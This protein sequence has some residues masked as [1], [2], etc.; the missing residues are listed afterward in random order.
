MLK[1]KYLTHIVTLITGIVL[2]A[3]LWSSTGF[4]GNISEGHSHT[5]SH[6]EETIWTCSMHPNIR[7]SEPGK[8][9][10]CAMDLIPAASGGGSEDPFTLVM[11]NEAVRLSEIRTTPARTGQ[12]TRE[13]RLPGR[14]TVDERGLSV[15]TAHFDGRI[16]SQNVNFVGAEVARGQVLATVWSPELIT[17]QQELLDAY[18]QRDRFPELYRS[19]REKLLFWDI[20]ESQIDG[21]VASGEI[22]REFE[23]LAPARGVVLQRNVRPQDYIARGQV[24]YEIADLSRVWVQFEA[25]EQDNQSLKVN[26]VVRFESPSFPGKSFAARINWIDPVVNP[27]SRTVRVRVN[28][29]NA[30][31]QWKPDMLV[32]GVVTS[33]HA[34]ERGVIVPASAIL[35]TGPR[36][37]LFVKLPDE[38]VPTFE[39]REVLLGQRSGDEWVILEGV[40]P[41]EL[42]VTNGAFKIDAEFQLRDKFSMMNRDVMPQR[43]GNVIQTSHS[44]GGGLAQTPTVIPVSGAFKVSLNRILDTY[45]IARDAF[46][47]SDAEKAFSSAGSLNEQITALRE[48]GLSAE[49]ASAWLL[50]QEQMKSNLRDWLRSSEIEKQRTAFY[51]TS[52]T[53]FEVLRKFDAGDVY[54]LQYC[55]MAFNDAG[56]TWLSRDEQ[57]ENPYLPETMLGCGEVIFRS[58]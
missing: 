7:Q 53:L 1:S 37:V 51:A 28:L 3:L 49:A 30:N 33:G 34:S 16:T 36:S 29:D 10:I 48:T 24:L 6:D 38:E 11:T 12:A 13:V 52:E 57:I 15:V 58:R 31:T 27:D 32:S 55:P 5:H 41:G 43:M 22:R 17:A 4:R 2:G 42:V 23:L 19:A 40:Q 54:F 50:A 45:I 18:R 44:G 46:V 25:Y 35:W 20:S 21:V 39:I 26:D 14:I 8:C 47:S 9:P 56:A